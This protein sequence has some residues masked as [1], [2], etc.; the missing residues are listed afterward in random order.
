LWS[1]EGQII[2]SRA[3]SLAICVPPPAVASELGARA[4][5]ELDMLVDRE[6][7]LEKK[8]SLPLGL[9]WVE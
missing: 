2:H 3:I 4:D 6:R 9:T 5:H 1:A 7:L 8:I